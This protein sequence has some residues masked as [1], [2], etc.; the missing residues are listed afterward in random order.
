V[1]EDQAATGA[2]VLSNTVGQQLVIN[3]ILVLDPLHLFIVSVNPARQ[4]KVVHDALFQ[5]P[6]LFRIFH[7]V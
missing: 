5:A 3:R 1:R 6:R 4:V 2:Q 7:L